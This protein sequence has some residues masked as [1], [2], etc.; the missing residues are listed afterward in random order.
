VKTGKALGI[1]PPSTNKTVITCDAESAKDLTEVDQAFIDAIATHNGRQPP[2]PA[3]EMPRVKREVVAPNGDTGKLEALLEHLDPDS[4]YEDWVHVLM[5]IHHESGGSDEGLQ[6]ADAWSSK[7]EKYQGSEEIRTKWASFADY[8]G[9]PITIATLHKMV[10]DQGLDV[11]K[12][13]SQAEPFPIF[14]TE[15]IHRQESTPACVTK[16]LMPLDRYS[17]RGMSAELERQAIDQVFILGDIALMGQLTVLYGA[18]NTGKTLLTKALLIEAIKAKRLDPEKLYYINVDDTLHGLTQKLQ[19][20][21]EFRY[22]TLAEGHRDFKSADLR[23][24]LYE[25][26]TNGHAQGTVVVLDTLKKFTDLMDKAKASAFGR[27]ARQFVMNGGTIIALAHVNKNR[28]KD[29]KPVYSGTTDIVDD[30][31]CAYVLDILDGSDP[32]ETVVVFENIKRRGDNAFQ[33]YYRYSRKSGQSYEALLAS[34][35]PV[36]ESQLLN[37][38][39][40]VEQQTDAEIIAAVTAS[41]NDGVVTKMK[42]ADAV[43]EKCGCSRRAAMR[44][45]DRYTGDDPT[46]HHWRY[47]VQEHGAKVFELLREPEP[48][49]A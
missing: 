30:A 21:E 36:D 33:A 24:H 15:V 17:L 39:R 35:S 8:Q 26:L 2:R 48:P 34:V 13:K 46:Q 40:A 29:G 43:A 14:E 20:A 31:D 44:I 19:I 1:L 38:Q 25:V 16:P 5:A 18:P 10:N 37:L 27:L 49:E 11:Q 12:V 47:T 7:G 41:I 3:P 23:R 22:H 42:L 6:L 45:V 9:R 28:G 32:A 4:G